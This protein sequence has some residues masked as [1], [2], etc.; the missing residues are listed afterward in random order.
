[1]FYVRLVGLS[2]DWGEANLERVRTLSKRENTMWAGIETFSAGNAADKGACTTTE[3]QGSDGDGGGGIGVTPVKIPHSAQAGQTTQSSAGSS[4]RVDEAA[5]VAREV[6]KPPPPLAAT[7]I[8]P[9]KTPSEACNGSTNENG[10]G[11]EPVGRRVAGGS[12]NGAG[13]SAGV[14]AGADVDVDVGAAPVDSREHAK[15]WKKT[16]PDLPSPAARKYA[17][18]YLA[19]CLKQTLQRKP[20]D[21]ARF[22]LP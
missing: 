3:G 8:V 10:N 21:M 22:V 9:D 7:M 1:M 15:G 14:T 16:L 6:L 13:V 20:D 4:P 19:T 18:T 5:A 2:R 11:K 12:S 17:A